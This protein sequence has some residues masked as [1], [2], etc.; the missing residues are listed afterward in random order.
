MVVAAQGPLTVCGLYTCKHVP[1]EKK[2]RESANQSY[3]SKVT[4]KKGKEKIQGVESV[5][6][7]CSSLSPPPSLSH[8]LF[9]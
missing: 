3:D 9:F 8:A 2:T 1:S 6:F 5:K 7:D 4:I